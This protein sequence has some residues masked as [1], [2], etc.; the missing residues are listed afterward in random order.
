MNNI[1]EDRDRAGSFGAEAERYDQTRPSY[2]SALID[3]L[4][5][6]GPGVAI[7]VGCGTGQ[8]TRL[9]CDAG[10]SITGVEAD[11]RMAAVARTRGLD[12]DVSTFEAWEGPTSS[13][14]LICSAQAWHWIDPVIGC[15]KAASHLV[16]GGKLALIWNSYHH[17]DAA[18]AVFNDVYGRHA[19]QLLDN[20]V[21]LGV[22]AIDH[23]DLDAVLE[24]DLGTDFA[25]LE[26]TTFEH[27]RE[28]AIEDWTAECLTHSSIALLPDDV[29][30]Q[31]LAEQSEALFE[32]VG[33]L[34]HVRYTAR[35]TT[36]RRV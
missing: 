29:R 12:V 33:P 20:A 22:A 23:T 9:L 5:A 35:L 6:S 10:W 3:T 24:R 7:D 30:D 16:P 15:P 26:I 13:L 32:A 18:T 28:Q 2:P 27:E 25:D 11:P 36:A 17:T 14:H 8:L 1:H 19:P 4:T 31:L 21:P 34:L